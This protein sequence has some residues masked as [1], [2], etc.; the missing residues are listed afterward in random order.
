MAVDVVFKILEIVG[1][2]ETINLKRDPQT[3]K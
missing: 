3:R 1:G 2:R